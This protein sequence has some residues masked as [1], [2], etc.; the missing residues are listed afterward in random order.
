MLVRLV[1]LK[2]KPGQ[3][4]AFREFFATIFDRVASSPGCLH[5]R[6]VQDADGGDDFFTISQWISTDALEAYRQSDFFKRVWP[7]VKTFLR[8]KPWAQSFQVVL[9]DSPVVYSLIVPSRNLTTDHQT[10]L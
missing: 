6:L 9:G 10:S 1:S 5:L 4:D 7:Q 3:A 2:V 8:E